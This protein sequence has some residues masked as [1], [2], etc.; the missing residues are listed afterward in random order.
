MATHTAAHYAKQF[1]PT[2]P[3]AIPAFLKVTRADAA[4]RRA[5]WAALPPAAPTTSQS[6]G[7]S[8]AKR[9]SASVPDEVLAEFEAE[10]ER[11]AAAKRARDRN[12]RKAAAEFV[13]PR[14]QNRV[15]MENRLANLRAYIAEQT[16]AKL[17]APRP[18]RSKKPVEITLEDVALWCH[19]WQTGAKP[20][21]PPLPKR[22]LPDMAP[23]G[24][25]TPKRTGRAPAQTNAVVISMLERPEGTTLDELATVTG[26]L[27]HSC[28]A[29]LSG[30]R[31]TRTIEKASE[32]RGTVYRLK[33]T[34]ETET[35]V[36][37]LKKL[38]KH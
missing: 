28:S 12:Q 6:F 9:V 25:A 37:L 14:V 31:K 34:P 22:A 16:A 35:R 7:G 38:A 19:Q 3:F 27:R 36:E 18:K 33:P 15:D 8:T 21:N 4:K 5:A 20:K 11:K 23:V 17:A 1:D 32:A 10:A 13:S 2:D 24:R 29:L 30:V 26:Q